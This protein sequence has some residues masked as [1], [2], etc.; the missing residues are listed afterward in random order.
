MSL[1]PWLIGQE[2]ANVR[3]IAA[4]TLAAL[5]RVMAV[6]ARLNRICVCVWLRLSVNIG[7]DEVEPHRS[8][9]GCIVVRQAECCGG[10]PAAHGN[11]DGAAATQLRP[12]G[13]ALRAVGRRVCVVT[14][15]GAAADY[16]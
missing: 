4:G 7:G 13:V 1:S 3:A 14:P 16:G 6:R 11:G 2:S 12:E 8:C 10:C 9:N 15:A 5:P